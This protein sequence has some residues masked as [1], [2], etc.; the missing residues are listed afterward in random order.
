M[1]YEKHEWVPYDETLSEAE[2][3]ERGA[4]VT[5]PKLNE[6]EKGIS[7]AHIDIDAVDES[8]KKELKKHL[9]DVANPHKTTAEQVGAYSATF[10]DTLANEFRMFDKVTRNVNR[11]S[12]T[13]DLGKLE[14]LDW[15]YIDKPTNLPPELE[16]VAI[17]G[18][19]VKMLTNTSMGVIF[20]TNHTSR[21]VYYGNAYGGTALV[22]NK[23]LNFNELNSLMYG[24]PQITKFNPSYK[25]KVRSST[26]A[27][28]N[29]LN[30][31][32]Q[33]SVILP[34]NA[35][36]V[37][38]PQSD[39]NAVSVDSATTAL[40]STSES[41]SKIQYLQRW[42]LLEE[43]R[44]TF[45]QLNGYS[46][47]QIL[48]LNP[49]AVVSTWAR[50]S[51]VGGNR[52]SFAATNGSSYDVLTANT[53]NEIREMKYTLN[54]A[55]LK[56]YMVSGNELFLNVYSEA[57][58][59][60]V[61]STVEIRYVELRISFN[62]PSF[63]D[64]LFAVLDYVPNGHRLFQLDGNAI[65]NPVEFDKDLA[66]ST[67][68]SHGPVYMNTVLNGPIGVP[69]SGFVTRTNVGAN[70]REVTYRPFNSRTTYSNTKLN[71]DKWQ[72]WQPLDG[73]AP[74]INTSAEQLTELP[75]IPMAL[76]Y[77]GLAANVSPTGLQAAGIFSSVYTTSVRLMVTFTDSSTGITY[78]NTRY[79]TA[80]LG[81]Q[82]VYQATPTLLK[83]GEDLNNL[84]GFPQSQKLYSAPTNGIAGSILNKPTQ[85]TNET[86]S[87][88]LIPSR[89][90]TAADYSTLQRLTAYIPGSSNAPRVFQRYVGMQT[91]AF[92]TLWK[93]F[94]SGLAD[95]V[96]KLEAAI[97]ALGGTV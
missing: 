83:S 9:D 45:P 53:T 90:N 58:D 57:S 21:R 23:S 39:Y 17:A 19:V 6:M 96:T 36:W 51:G 32:V 13:Y 40:L 46:M 38:S 73:N 84:K 92:A 86:F 47:A 93:E 50:G 52:V 34:N 8:A 60:T 64:S 1:S 87:I 5:A 2:N 24:V 12:D 7:D 43:F 10:L 75:T 76:Q 31:V 35:A 55:A 54:A 61:P 14:S 65:Q 3:I 48:L 71:T 79:N 15:T 49:S 29:I 22:W 70:I 67:A 27:N 74:V 33:S 88:E 25:N 20:I 72:G 56:H 44:R 95:R 42:N 16:G 69:N 97:V 89:I 63:K 11:I 94:D 91:G 59:G 81:W 82:E 41:G 4:V 68:Y 30:R 85:L 78:T 37:E 77:A 80:W 26:V 18:W 66:S 28:P 62:L